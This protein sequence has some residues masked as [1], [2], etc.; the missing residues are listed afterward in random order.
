MVD[1]VLTAALRSNLL[2]LQ[3]TQRDIDAVQFRLASERKVNSA[4]DNPQSFFAAQSLTNRANDLSRLLDGIGQSISTIKQADKGVTS[5]TK[6]VEQADAIANQALTASSA[7]AQQAKI[8]GNVSLTGVLDLTDLAGVDQTADAVELSFSATNAA[9]TAV[10]LSATEVDVEGTIE[11]FVAGINAITDTATGEQAIQASLDDKGQLQIASLTGGKLRIEFDNDDSTDLDLAKA[12]GFGDQVG[13]DTVAAGIADP[14]AGATIGVTVLG[15][16][17]AESRAFYSAANTI[18]TRSTQ[19]DALKDSTGATA[20]FADTENSAT[21]AISVN[22]KANQTLAGVTIGSSSIQDV[23]D[24]INTNAS[25]KTEIQASFDESTGKISI[26]A[27]D[28]SVE[29]LKIT[30]DNPDAGTA[31]ATAAFGFGVLDGTTAITTDLTRVETIRLGSAA[32][33]LARLESDFNEVR[34]QIDQLVTDS[35]YQGINLLNGDDLT[36]VFNEDRSSSLTTQGVTYTSAGLDLS[37]ANFGTSASVATTLT[38]IRS[39]TSEIRGFGSQLSNS[40]A[41]IQIRKDF[42]E[43]TINTLTEGSDKLTLA[44]KNE[45]GAKLL[46]LQTRQQLGIISLSLASQSAQSVLRLF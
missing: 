17:A 12:L 14:S 41:V 37:A 44:D 28:S 40:L 20:Q 13:F 45:E 5:L 16:P 7:G 39:A 11:Q 43:Q 19:L 35:G 38:E 9:G 2:T 42:T 27:I 29:T 15:T 1:T 18:A 6:L 23:V 26:R 10:T 34:S 25:L 36:T 32:G 30:V 46:A 24:A 4:L 31:D 3:G 8:T 22:G 33:E 21:I